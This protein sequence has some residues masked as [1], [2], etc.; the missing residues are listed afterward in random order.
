MNLNKNFSLKKMVLSAAVVLALIVASCGNNGTTN[1]QEQTTETPVETAPVT[2]SGTY[3][4]EP[5]S[6]IEWKGSKPT[7]SH[8]GTIC[9]TK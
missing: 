5:T 7:G 6:V 8:T 4:A 1:N 3:T 9:T 2:A